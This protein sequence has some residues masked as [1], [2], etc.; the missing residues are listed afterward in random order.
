MRRG[1]LPKGAP[2]AGAVVQY[3]G[4]IDGVRRIAQEE[5]FKGLYRGLGPSLVMVKIPLVSC[6]LSLNEHGQGVLDPGKHS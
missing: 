3:K 5:G 1:S 2:T 4:L 6:K